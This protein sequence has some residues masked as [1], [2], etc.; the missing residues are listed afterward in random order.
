[1]MS[2]TAALVYWGVVALIAGIVTIYIA[3]GDDE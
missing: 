3:R 1:M 2:P